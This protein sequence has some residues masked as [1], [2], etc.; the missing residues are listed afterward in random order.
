MLHFVSAALTLTAFITGMI[1][2]TT[3]GWSIG[4][5][6]RPYDGATAKYKF[7]MWEVCNTNTAGV[8]SCTKLTDSAAWEGLCHSASDYVSR[9]RATEAFGILQLISSFAAVGLIAV[10]VIKNNQSLFGASAGAAIFSGISALICFAIEL[11]TLDNYYACGSSLC[12]LVKKSASSNGLTAS[13]GYDYSFGLMV[14]AC[15]L[16][17]IGGVL[18][19]V[20]SKNTGAAAATEPSAPA[21]AAETNA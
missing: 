19:F 20:H 16:G 9:I 8:E 3:N 12:D 6:T 18:A 21:A 2:V 7:G 13:C 10:A 17:F 1:S 5:V 15:G 11:G 14:V 4:V